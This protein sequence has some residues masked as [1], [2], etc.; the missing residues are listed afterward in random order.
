M[1]VITAE[2]LPH[3]PGTVLSETPPVGCVSA[4]VFARTPPND[5]HWK[6]GDP[7]HHVMILLKLE[8]RAHV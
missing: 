6:P 1:L 2:R 7:V 3:N 8:L 4:I 5:G